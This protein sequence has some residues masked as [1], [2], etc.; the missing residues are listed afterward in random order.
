MILDFA[1]WNAD[2]VYS[3]LNLH[4]KTGQR[5]SYKSMVLQCQPGPLCA[6]IYLHVF[7][8]ET[9]LHLEDEQGLMDKPGNKSYIE[10]GVK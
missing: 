6:G 5:I 10:K 1:S 3:Y 9:I 2:I 7:L 8:A 4:I